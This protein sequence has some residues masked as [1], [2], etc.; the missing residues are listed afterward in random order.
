MTTNS[1]RRS[2]WRQP[3]SVAQLLDRL[4]NIRRLR[5][6]QYSGEP[7]AIKVSISID[8]MSL[9]YQSTPLSAACRS[10]RAMQAK[11]PS[12]P[13]SSRF[14]DGRPACRSGKAP[15]TVQVPTL[16]GGLVALSISAVHSAFTL[17]VVTVRS[18][19]SAPARSKSMNPVDKALSAWCW[20]TA[21]AK[22]QCAKQR[23]WMQL[24]YAW[25]P[26]MSRSGSFTFN[27]RRSSA[28]PLIL[29]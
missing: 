23:L 14:A 13:C 21:S 1:S 27:R 9:A 7:A 3:V 16:V 28:M 10:I 18:D 12:V 25:R 29:R 2:R 15:A 17:I 20:R 5:T 26:R 4:L 11:W 22:V 24:R 8:A 19:R 6:R